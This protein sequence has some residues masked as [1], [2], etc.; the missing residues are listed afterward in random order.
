MGFGDAR[1]PQQSTTGIDAVFGLIG[2]RTG[3]H[4]WVLVWLV[5]LRKSF[6][7]LTGFK[8]L[9]GVKINK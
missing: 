1:H 2:G 7:H 8:N 9:S 4:L 5:K 3:L 6:L